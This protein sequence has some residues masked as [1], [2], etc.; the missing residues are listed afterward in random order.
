MSSGFVRF[1][2]SGTNRSPE[3]QIQYYLKV[4]TRDPSIYYTII[5]FNFGRYED[6]SPRKIKYYFFRVENPHIYRN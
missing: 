1:A 4:I 2:V 6:L 3:K 5:D